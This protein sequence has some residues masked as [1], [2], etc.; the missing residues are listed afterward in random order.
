MNK[1]LKGVKAFIW[2][3][4][5]TLFDTYPRTIECF[6]G[7]LKSLGRDAARGDIYS[8]MM[9]SITHAF[10]YYSEKFFGGDEK[11]LREA[12]DRACDSPIEFQG[13]PFDFAAEVLETVLSHGGENYMFTHRQNDVYLFLD[14]WNMRGYFKDILTLADDVI[15]KPSPDAI[16]KLAEKHGFEKSKAVMIGDREIDISCGA[17]AGTLTC[18]ITNGLP[19]GSFAADIRVENLRELLSLIKKGFNG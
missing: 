4:D 2:D 10:A 1:S 17:N 12:Y 15:P 6:R 9:V 18:H 14:H 5:G 3:F 16:D 8:L 19:H 13:G 11:M 7:A